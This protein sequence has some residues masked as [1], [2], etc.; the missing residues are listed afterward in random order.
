VTPLDF[1]ENKPKK[2]ILCDHV[3]QQEKR[4]MNMQICPLVTLYDS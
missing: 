4:H 2:C 3:F 1:H